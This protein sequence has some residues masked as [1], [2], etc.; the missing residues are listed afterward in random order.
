MTGIYQDAFR[1]RVVDA[2]EG[3]MSRRGAARHFGIAASTAIH[4]MKR[5]KTT[6]SFSRLEM[7]GDHS[8]K[9]TGY[10]EILPDLVDHNMDITR[11]EI[12]LFLR[13]QNIKITAST[14]SRF[15]KKQGISFKKNAECC[16]ARPP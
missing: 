7:G 9:L 6:G 4:W 14:V 13:P 15:L 11:E 12:C 16:G 10:K 3:G 5:H 1:R 2:I 8:S